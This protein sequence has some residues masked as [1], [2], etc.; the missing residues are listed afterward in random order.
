[1]L[2]LE[3]GAPVVGRQR[4]IVVGCGVGGL[5]SALELAHHGCEVTVVEAA[6]GPGG[7]LRQVQVGGCLLDAGPTVFTMRG[8]FDALFADVGETLSAHLGLRRLKTLARHTWDGRQVL[9]L[10]ADLARSAHAIG[11]FAG[12]DE[13][14]RYLDF[15][16]RTRQIHQALEATFIHAP[17]TGVM[18]L[19]GR[20]ARR[21]VS[22]LAHMAPFRSMWTAL[23]RYFRDPRLRQLFG[24]YAT[25]CGS[26]PFMAPATLMLVAHVEQQGVWSLDG[27][28]HRLAGALATLAGRRGAVF[29][30]DSP[31]RE[32]LVTHGRAAGVRLVNGDTLPAEAV[33]F[34]GDCSALAAGLLG[35]QVRHAVPRHAATARSLSAVTWNVVAPAAGFGLLR[36]NVFFSGSSPNEFGDLFER[37]RLPVDPTVYVCAQD[38]GDPCDPAPRGPERLLCLVNAPA[39]ADRQR[40]DAQAI[41]RCEDAAFERLARCGLR[42]YRDEGQTLRTTPH[43]FATLFPG[44][45]G[46]LYGPASHGWQASF[47]RSGARSALEGLYLAGGSTHP[48]PGV[49]MAALSGR[50]AAASLLADFAATTRRSRA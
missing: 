9:D 41:A 6:S 27:G 23:G 10:H 19:T 8:V 49:P 1:V 45:G 35:S 50:Q 28:M 13:A 25:Y 34:N 14:G 36:H 26:S 32:L 7:K 2:N 42:L 16:Q 33:V 12:A 44:T 39:T 37:E 38:R 47:R 48:G 4:V 18:G 30:Y 22:G 11:E 3:K 24:R 20:V 5:V 40:D 21:S 17:R 46:A 15:C 31:V 29:V 43:D